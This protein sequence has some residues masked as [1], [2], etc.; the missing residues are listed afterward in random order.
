MSRPRMSSVTL[1]GISSRSSSSAVI[2][3]VGFT[4][5]T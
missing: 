1:P 3:G 4:E 2:N 5:G